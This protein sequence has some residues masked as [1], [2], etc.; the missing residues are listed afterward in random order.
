MKIPAYEIMSIRTWDSTPLIVFVSYE[1]KVILSPGAI[2]LKSLPTMRM[3]LTQGCAR[4]C[5]DLKVLVGVWGVH[6]FVSRGSV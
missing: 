5:R 2:V 3:V 4:R 6:G 1:V